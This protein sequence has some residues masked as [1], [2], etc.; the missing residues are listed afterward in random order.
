MLSKTSMRC[1]L[2]GADRWNMIARILRRGAAM[3]YRYLGPQRLKVSAV[4]YGCPPFQGQLSPADERQA[5]AVLQHAIA[6][7]DVET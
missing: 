3:Q 7:G 6:I 2:I 1:N 4:G 5:I